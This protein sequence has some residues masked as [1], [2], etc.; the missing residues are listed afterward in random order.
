MQNTKEIKSFYQKQITANLTKTIK[1][2]ETEGFTRNTFTTL[3]FLQDDLQSL[4]AVE[5]FFNA[6]HP[7]GNQNN[8]RGA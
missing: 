6:W 5:G 1:Q 2:I 4:N 3:R 7:E 8:K